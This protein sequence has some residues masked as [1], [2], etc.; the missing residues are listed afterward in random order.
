MNEY[1]LE[2]FKQARDE[3]LLSLDETKIRE[4]FRK[5]NHRELPSNTYTFWGAVHKAITGNAGLPL[6]FRKQ[7][8]AWLD[9]HNLKSLDDGDL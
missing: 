8:K 1:T 9:K 6:Q 3:A 5:F 7:S 2:E 4:M